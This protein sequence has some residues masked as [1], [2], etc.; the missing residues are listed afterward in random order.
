MINIDK[1]ICTHFLKFLVTIVFVCLIIYISKNLEESFT[2]C[3]ETR[4]RIIQCDKLP[5]PVK[6][7]LNINNS[8]TKINL[9]WSRQENNIEKYIIVMY[10]N[11]DGPYFINP[12]IN[13]ENNLYNYS[14][15]DP[16]F[17][18]RYKFAVVAV[19]SFGVG[20]IDKFNEGILTPDGLEL[21]YIESIYS[22]VTCNPDGTYSIGDKCKNNNIISAISHIDDENNPIDF[23]DESHNKLMRE[24][25]N[26]PKIK[27]NLQ[28]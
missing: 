5:K 3:P 17:N 26:N 19:N 10:K 1:N 7:T 2:A 13:T 24:L 15:H 23:S 21:N 8:K 22:K 12:N 28:F 6:L 9:N 4:E 16:I 14:F 11:N 20:N 27:L 18:V 25:N